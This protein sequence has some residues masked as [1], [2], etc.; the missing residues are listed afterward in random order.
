M[1]FDPLSLQKVTIMTLFWDMWRVLSNFG[2][3]G[4]KF[5]YFFNRGPKLQHFKT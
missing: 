1:I 2:M 4:A 3:K 5:S